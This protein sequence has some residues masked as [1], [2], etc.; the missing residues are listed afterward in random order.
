[1]AVTDYRT[2]LGAKKV[3]KLTFLRKNLHALKQLDEEKEAVENDRK[4]KSID[5]HGSENGHEHEQQTPSSIPKKHRID[6]DNVV[7][8]EDE[9]EH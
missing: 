6:N 1:M 4:R 3:N 7:S 8:S 9:L 5:E 2:R